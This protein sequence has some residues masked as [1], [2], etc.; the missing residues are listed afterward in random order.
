MEG[1]GVDATAREDLIA[2][3]RWAQLESGGL[4]QPTVSSAPLV[5]L[6]FQQ[7]CRQQ[8]SCRPLTKATMGELMTVDRLRRC[9]C[10]ASVL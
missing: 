7:Y 10:S 2:A 9:G 3:M 5:L 4:Y 8:V 1:Q 6:L